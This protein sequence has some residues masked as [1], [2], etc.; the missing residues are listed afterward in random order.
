MLSIEY[1]VAELGCSA[2]QLAIAWCLKNPNVSTCLLG[3]T[4]PEQLEETIGAL[5]VVRKLTAE[6][7]EQIDAILENKPEGYA[8]YGAPFWARTVDT[9]D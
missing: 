3:A 6:H 7:M 4:K 5:D 8:G 2:A 9:L 1:W